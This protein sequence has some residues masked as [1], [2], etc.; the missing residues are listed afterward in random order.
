M[1]FSKL[2]IEKIPKL[3]LILLLVLLPA[4]SEDI[5]MEQENWTKHTIGKIQNPS[6]VY[7]AD[8]DAD[9]APDIAVSTTKDFGKYNSEIAWFRN[10]GTDSWEK[11]TVSAP[12]SAEPVYNA[13]GITVADID[14]NGNSDI[15]VATSGGFQSFQDTD[16]G[17]SLY[18]F[19]AVNKQ[20]G[21]WQK[22]NIE[23]DAEDKYWKVYTA[24]PNEDGY[25]E[26]IVGGSKSAYI[27]VNP[28]SA[29][30]DG[31]T[32]DEKV[33]LPEGTGLYIN[34]DDLNND[35]K[36]DILS[37]NFMS[38]KISWIDMSYTDGMLSFKEHVV[39][40]GLKG[41]FDIM[42]IDIS[43]RE[44]KD[45]VV[46]K[47]RGGGIHWFEAPSEESD[48]WTM[49]F[50]DSTFE[51]T[52]LYT[53]DINNDGQ[54][55]FV[56]SGFS[57]SMGIAPLLRPDNITWFEYKKEGSGIVWEKHYIDAS[58]INIPGDISLN[59]INA[60][61]YPDVVTVSYKDGEVVWYENIFAEKILNQ[62]VCSKTR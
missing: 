28:G 35:G 11:V 12:D 34:L 19:K 46:S 41:T 47:I 57:M 40:E 31:S 27:F 22:F 45:L 53:G 51:A 37:S 16:G 20:T 30:E 15:V 29:A 42:G 55:D 21:T 24:D 2:I 1:I 26:I 49:R 54:T 10:N 5:I 58:S 8:I 25:P 6:Y 32:W 60:D 52:D 59:D 23:T 4:C 14:N 7:V 62:D 56:V 36:F 18:W 13:M 44:I 39:Y 43:G 61:G 3:S 33:I 50:V 17:G 38:Q 48:E 9:G